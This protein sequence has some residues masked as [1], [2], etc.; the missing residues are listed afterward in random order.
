MSIK[1]RYFKMNEHDSRHYHREWLDSVCR[2][3]Q[4]LIDDFLSN[5]NARGYSY[6]WYCGDFF[7]KSILVHE[8][9]DV[10][11]NK[12]VLSDKFDEDGRTLFSVTPDRRFR[13][14]KKLNK[15]L[16]IL[17]E[18]LKQ[19]PAFSTWMVNKLDCYFEV[20]GISNGRTVMA[21]SSAGFYGDK[22]AVVVRI[23]VGESDNAFSPEKLHPSLM[24][25][26][27]SEFIAI[28]EE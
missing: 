28:T 8:D 14:G 5:Q 12:R 13:E 22:G 10:G 16:N 9:V 27:H 17:N 6:S 2:E 11:R 21:C 26:K 3:R 24:A 25:I 4:K 20:F 1:Y 15:A 7:V 18:K 23:P 19:L